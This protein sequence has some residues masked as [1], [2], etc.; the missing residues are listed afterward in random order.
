MKNFVLLRLCFFVS[1]L[2]AQTTSAQ[3]QIDW[4]TYNNQ[5]NYNVYQLNNT[6]TKSFNSIAESYINTLKLE[7]SINNTSNYYI[8]LKAKKYLMIYNEKLSIQNTNNFNKA[9]IDKS[10]SIDKNFEIYIY[11][12]ISDMFYNIKNTIDFPNDF[13]KENTFKNDDFELKLFNGSTLSNDDFI[14]EETNIQFYNNNTINNIRSIELDN[15]IKRA[16]S[17]SQN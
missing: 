7:S 10:I 11:D 12:T 17:L 3:I 14:P 16:I 15:I 5:N 4:S 6:N 1:I 2:F 9:N 13:P 8:I